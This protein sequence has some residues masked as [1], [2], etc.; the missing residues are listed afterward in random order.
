MYIYRKT[1]VCK[2]K[3]NPST[4]PTLRVRPIIRMQIEN[5]FDCLTKGFTN[6]VKLM[7]NR[8][9]KTLLNT[10]SLLSL[11]LSLPS[12]LLIFNFLLIDFYNSQFLTRRVLTGGHL[13]G[14][15][16]LHQR[17]FQRPLTTVGSRIPLIRTSWTS[18]LEPE[19]SVRSY[20]GLG[21]T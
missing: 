8:Y 1:P 3:K 4:D 2:N 5:L 13:V 17:T 14:G 11:S 18:K 6:L 12:P 15:P 9:S 21:G 19:K 16:F 20:T 7:V 10:S